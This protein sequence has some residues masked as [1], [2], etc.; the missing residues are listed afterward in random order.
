MK[1]FTERKKHGTPE[2]WQPQFLRA[3]DSWMAPYFDARDPSARD[4]RRKYFGGPMS[5][6]PAH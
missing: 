4:T 1:F 3:D 5:D 6:S 2:D